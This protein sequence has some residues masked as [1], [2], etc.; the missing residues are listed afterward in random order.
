MSYSYYKVGGQL[1]QLKKCDNPECPRL[2]SAAYCCGSCNAAH[3]GRYEIHESGPLA[4]T[5]TCDERHEARKD[6]KRW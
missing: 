6:A 3:D 1:I 2:T 5:T 4:H